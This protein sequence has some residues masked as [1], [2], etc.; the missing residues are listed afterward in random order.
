MKPEERQAKP[1]I[2]MMAQL[3][4]FPYRSFDDAFVV[5]RFWEI[6]DKDSFFTET[7]PRIRGLVAAGPRKIDAPF[8]DRLPNVEIIANIG[9]GYDRLDIAA[10]AARDIVATNT[11]DVLTDEVADLTVGLLLATVRRIPHAERFL[12]SGQWKAGGFPYSPSLRG[13]RVGILG[14]GRIGKAIARRLSGFDVTIVYCGRS[15][16]SDV[17]FPFYPS[18]LQM[19]RD[20]DVLIAAVPGTAG[21]RNMIDADVLA[22]LGPDGVFINVARGSVVDEAA[23]I[24]AL[25]QKAILAAGLDV[26]AAEPEIPEALL[27]LDNVVLTPH[28]GSASVRTRSEMIDLLFENLTSWFAGEGPKTPVAETPWPARAQRPSEAA[29]PACQSC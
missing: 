3:A 5:H 15:Q 25:Q 11:P 22:A 7:A 12:R 29:V 1:E 19:A 27:A 4:R 20:V 18:A 8:L 13:R 23:L 21:T 28:I 2:L 17:S 14:L 24:A 26:F 10:V 9:V 16:Q 6:D